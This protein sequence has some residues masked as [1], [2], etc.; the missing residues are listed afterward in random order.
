MRYLF[1][2]LSL[3]LTA[4]PLGYALEATAGTQNFQMQA[5]KRQMSEQMIA[6]TA[7]VEALATKLK[8]VEDK[9]EVAEGCG[10]DGKLYAPNNASSDADGCL[11]VEAG[12]ESTPME[13]VTQHSCTPGASYQELYTPSHACHQATYRTYTCVEN[14]EMQDNVMY[15]TSSWQHTASSAMFA[16]CGGG[17]P[18]GGR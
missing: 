8:V 9:V 6:L 16:N 13:V 3:S 14:T 2:I 17:E 11:E 10:D 12:G 18:Q 1:I 4:V 15:L 7:I 5:L